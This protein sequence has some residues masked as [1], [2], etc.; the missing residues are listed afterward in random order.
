MQKH[1]KRAFIL[2]GYKPHKRLIIKPIIKRF[3]I[4]KG[5]Y[6]EG[7]LFRFILN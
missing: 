1:Q 3:F 5:V 2:R 6:T 7:C 4:K